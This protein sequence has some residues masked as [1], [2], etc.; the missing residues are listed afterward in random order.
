MDQ[1]QPIDTLRDGRLKATI[2]ENVN[3]QNDTYHSV[4]LA[5]TYEDRNGKLQDTASF[6]AGELL[7]VAELAREAHSVIRDMRRE[8]AHEVRAERNTNSRER[9]SR[10]ERPSR[11]RGRASSPGLER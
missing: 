8:R 7:R 6:S 9:P 2:W 4:T 1:N 10:E 11:F 5:K 3:E